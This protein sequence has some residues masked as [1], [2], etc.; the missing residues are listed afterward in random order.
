MTVPVKRDLFT[1]RIEMFPVRYPEFA[2]FVDAIHNSYWLFTEYNYDT[3]IQHYK[4]EL[5][6][7]ER[8]VITRAMLAI[9]Q[10]E[11]NVKRFW[12]DIYYLYP[13]PEIDEVGVVF[14]DSEQR[15]LAAYRHLLERMGLIEDFSRIKEIPQLMARITYME[16]FMRDKNLSK[17]EATLSMV[18][19]SMFI[20]HISLFSQFLLISS[21]NKYRNIF[22]GISNAIEATS[23]EEQLHGQFGITIFGI[24]AREHHDI[25]TPNMYKRLE[26]MADQAFKAEMDIVDWIFGEGD[27]DFMPKEAIKNYVRKRYNDSLQT[28]GIAPKHDV[29]A[30]L[31]KLAEYFDLE[32]LTTKETDFFNKRSTD[33]TKFDTAITGDDLF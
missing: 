30:E 22:K 18:L 3:D 24:I 15:H 25:L 32:I 10:I 14:A 9:S 4:V 33:Y 12:A 1:K 16:N 23:K 7:Y 20:E 31:Y 8:G 11:V 17:E 26:E 29:D 13:Q 27:L 5:N 6:E 28:L 2:P 21:Y 19:F